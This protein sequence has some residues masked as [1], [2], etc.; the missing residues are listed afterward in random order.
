MKRLERRRAKR[1]KAKRIRYYDVCWGYW[2][3]LYDLSDE[4]RIGIWYRAWLGEQVW[5]D[6]IKRG[7]NCPMRYADNT[8]MN[9]DTDDYWCPYRRDEKLARLDFNEQLKE[10][11]NREELDEIDNDYWSRPYSPMQDVWTDNHPDL[12]DGWD[13]D[14][15]DYEIAKR[16]TNDRP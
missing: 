14:E 4:S 1:L 15:V 16:Y 6:R 5:R 2:W 3:A 13:W 9:K 12:T 8:A 10:F 7:L 11:K